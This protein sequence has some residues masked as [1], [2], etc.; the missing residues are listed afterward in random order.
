MTNLITF[1]DIR[2]YYEFDD[3]GILTNASIRLISKFITE[4]TDTDEICK[5]YAVVP[6]KCSPLMMDNMKVNYQAKIYSQICENEHNIYTFNNVM[7]NHYQGGVEDWLL[8]LAESRVGR[9]DE[10]IRLNCL[11]MLNKYNKRT[12]ETL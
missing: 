3:L 1:V 4:Q 2:D 11:E 9:T 8:L 5:Y 6:S 10:Q 7:L 12:Y